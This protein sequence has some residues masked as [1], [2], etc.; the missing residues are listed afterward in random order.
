MGAIKGALLMKSIEL[1]NAAV[2]L[3]YRRF[4][5]AGIKDLFEKGET[6]LS[7]AIP[8]LLRIGLSHLDGGWRH[9]VLDQPWWKQ[10]L[11]MVAMQTSFYMDDLITLLWLATRSEVSFALYCVALVLFIGADFARK[12]LQMETLLAAT[13]ALSS[14]GN[15]LV[16]YFKAFGSMPTWQAVCIILFS[17]S[18][19]V[20]VH[21]HNL[22]IIFN[23]VRNVVQT[24]PS[25]CWTAFF[26]TFCSAVL[27]SG[28]ERRA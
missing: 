27:S 16:E 5:A 14:G 23:A 8:P 19:T 20:F 13:D 12:V 9:W 18:S 26:L 10:L 6:S 25:V 22:F 2:F 24:Q 7:R 28:I 3:V 11:V 21:G 1:I 17:V 15:I 4:Y